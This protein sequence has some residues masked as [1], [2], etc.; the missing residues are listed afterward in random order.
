[1][2]NLFSLLRGNRCCCALFTTVLVCLDH[3]SLLVMWTP[4]NLAPIN[5]CRCQWG[6]AWPSFSYSPRSAPLS[7]NECFVVGGAP[8]L[9][10]EPRHTGNNFDCFQSYPDRPWTLNQPQHPATSRRGSDIKV[11]WWRGV[12]FPWCQNSL[13]L[14]SGGQGRRVLNFLLRV[15]IV[16]STRWCIT[17][18]S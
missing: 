15:V 11:D 16:E 10:K 3:D 14:S 13:Y 12:S 1:M 6:P 7:C 17:S 9:F 2:S 8:G 4:R 18:S 5:I